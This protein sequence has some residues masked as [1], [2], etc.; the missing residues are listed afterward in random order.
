MKYQKEEL[1]SYWKRNYK[2]FFDYS[3][4]AFDKVR[5]SSQ[6]LSTRPMAPMPK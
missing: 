5:P 3:C 2:D 6:I 1:E 4:T